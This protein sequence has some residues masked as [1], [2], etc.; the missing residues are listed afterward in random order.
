MAGCPS[1]GKRAHSLAPHLEAPLHTRPTTGRPQATAAVLLVA[2]EGGE[3]TPCQAWPYACH[4][5]NQESSCAPDGTRR[6][7]QRM[8]CQQ[9]LPSSLVLA[10]PY[11]AREE[12]GQVGT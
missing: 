7:L 8:V 5:C 3:P 2:E 9:L 1:S 11:Q 4:R 10:T 6:A 12:E